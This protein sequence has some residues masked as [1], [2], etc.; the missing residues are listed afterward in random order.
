MA[1]LMGH[2]DQE[3]LTKSSHSASFLVQDLR[4]LV[5]AGNPLLGEIAIE[6]LQQAVLIE[7]RIK[8]V[9]TAACTPESEDDAVMAPTA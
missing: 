8:R 9:E 6:L 4:D 2:M 5:K 1:S 3:R 7:Q